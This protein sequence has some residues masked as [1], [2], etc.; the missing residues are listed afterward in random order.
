MPYIPG[1][2]TKTGDA[3]KV[4]ILHSKMYHG[5]GYFIRATPQGRSYR[6]CA[7]CKRLVDLHGHED[8]CKYGEALRDSYPDYAEYVKR[9]AECGIKDTIPFL[10]YD[11]FVAVI[12]NYSGDD[13]DIEHILLL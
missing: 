8:E 3:L 6:I 11:E 13:T 1:R 12:N 5:Y 9:Y 7:L 2:T 10:E 4:H